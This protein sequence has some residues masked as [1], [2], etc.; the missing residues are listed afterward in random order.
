MERV[1]YACDE[2]SGLIQACHSVRPS[3]SVQDLD[4]QVAQEEVQGQALRCRLIAMKA[5]TAVIR[6]G[7]ELNE[8]SRLGPWS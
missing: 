7:A 3:Q 1:L 2:L 8:R 4:G 5:A 6:H